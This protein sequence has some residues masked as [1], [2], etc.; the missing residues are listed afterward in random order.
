MSR[1]KKTIGTVVMVIVPA[2][3]M[4]VTTEAV[5]QSRGRSIRIPRRSGRGLRVPSAIGRSGRSGLRGLSR[6]NGSRGNLLSGSSRSG[7]PVLEGLGALL[8]EAGRNYRHGD[9]HKGYGAWNHHWDHHDYYSDAE[10]YRDVGIAN[11]VVD[12]IG[13]LVNASAYQTYAPVATAPVE[14]VPGPVEPVPVPSAGPVTVVPAPTVVVQT[15]VYRTPP[16]KKE[17]GRTLRDRSRP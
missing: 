6:G 4:L 9:D 8:D 17:G 3:L 7:F 13:I 14:V 15:P 1:A 10:A 11:A 16:R 2:S 12:L 5:A